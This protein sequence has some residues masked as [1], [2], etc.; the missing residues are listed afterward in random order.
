MRSWRTL[1]FWVMPS[2]ELDV[3]FFLPSFLLIYIAHD[4][5]APLPTCPRVGAYDRSKV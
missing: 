5:L 4:I 2:F 3:R 1:L